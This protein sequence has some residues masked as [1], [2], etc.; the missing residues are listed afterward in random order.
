M[1]RA[2]K[3]FG[4]PDGIDLQVANVNKAWDRIG[5]PGIPNLGALVSTLYREHMGRRGAD[6]CVA[7]LGGNEHSILG[8]LDGDRPFDFTLPDHPDLPLLAGREALSYGLVKSVMEQKVHGA[9]RHLN[10]F[11]ENITCPLVVV[12]VPP[13]IPDNV[14]V[15]EF[16]DKF[17][18]SQQDAPHVAPAVLRWK[19]WALQCEIT[20]RFADQ[21]GAFYMPTPAEV[22]NTEGF[23]HPDYWG[24]DA[25]HGNTA[26][27]Q[28]INLAL[29]DMCQQFQD[30]LVCHA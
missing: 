19:M 15:A 26:Y 13:P 18:Q 29:G 1:T 11:S 4:A 27:G 28:V 10:P 30:S 16:L 23:L 2:L 7:R 14:Y 21:I 6:L 5:A 22:F 17:F 9:L 12:E 3:A 24:V 25:T 8:T 20:R